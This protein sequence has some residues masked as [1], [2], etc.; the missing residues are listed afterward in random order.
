MFNAWQVFKGLIV[1]YAHGTK[2]KRDE[3]DHK[4]MPEHSE[5][6]CETSEG[7]NVI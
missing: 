7:G 2:T 1:I 5:S 4:N 3:I 6:K